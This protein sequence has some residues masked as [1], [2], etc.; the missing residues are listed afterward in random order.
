MTVRDALN[1]A[2]D[3]E[4]T[5][6]DSVFIMGEEV[7]Q[8]AAFTSVGWTHPVAALQHQSQASRW[9]C[10]LRLVPR[11]MWSCCQLGSVEC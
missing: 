8:L 4:M 2:L 9:C 6:D 10:V 7:R 11:D 3:E 5:R 1:S